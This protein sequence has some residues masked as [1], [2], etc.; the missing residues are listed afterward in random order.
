MSSSLS[1]A[2]QIFETI[3]DDPIVS[4]HGHCDPIWFAE[5]GQFPDPA[6]LLLIPDHYLFR[7]LYSQGIGLADLGIGVP[8]QDRDARAIFKRLASNWHLFLGTPSRGWLGDTLS[9]IFDIQ[10]ELSANTSDEIFDH[11]AAELKTPAF[12][13]RVMF[14][15]FNIE[16][17]ATT[18]S[19]T[20]DLA[21]HS[22][23]RASGW[24]GR[25]IPTFRPDAVLDPGHDQFLVELDKLETMTGSDLGLYSGYLEAL[26]Q[27]RQA[28]IA[29]GATASDH[30][31]EQIQT[32]W[33]PE[34]IEQLYAKVRTGDASDAEKTH[35]L[36]PYAGGNGA[37]VGRGRAGHANPRGQPTQ[38]KCTGIRRVWP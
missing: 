7:M 4:P 25:V 30:A 19:A 14:E 11:I 28:F 26:R 32:A 38:H 35:V 8:E 3:A 23:I 24:S 36:C 33:L 22:A 5:N 9:N 27:R 16:V 10:T 13:P 1:S 17:L 2:H 34:K 20:D 12:R 15:R 31:I 29:L 18:D 37:D 21:H 6:D